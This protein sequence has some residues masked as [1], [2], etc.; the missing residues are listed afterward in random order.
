MGLANRVVAHF[1]MLFRGNGSVSSI[2]LESPVWIMAIVAPIWLT[3]SQFGLI[4]C[5]VALFLCILLPYTVSIVRAFLLGDDAHQFYTRGTV[6]NREFGWWAP[7][8]GLPRHPSPD[9]PPPPAEEEPEEPVNIEELIIVKRAIHG[10]GNAGAMAHKEEQSSYQTTH[11]KG[12][13]LLPTS[14]LCGICLE[15]Y[16]DGDEIAWS[17]S[18]NCHHAFHA[19]C[20]REWLTSREKKKQVCPVCRESYHADCGANETRE[21]AEIELSPAVRPTTVDVELGESPTDP[22]SDAASDSEF[23]R[24]SSDRHEQ[25]SI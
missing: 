18:P 12:D 16:Q 5:L 2:I 23:Q 14:E 10:Q 6:R 19:T 25:V 22:S 11:P 4:P 1:H 13:I 24:D 15:E 17:N 7:L 8:L 9:D 3:Y 21:A 20:L